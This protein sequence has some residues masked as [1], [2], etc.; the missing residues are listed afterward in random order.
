MENCKTDNIANK[1]FRSYWKW[2]K[3]SLSN[4]HLYQGLKY[5]K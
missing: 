3:L 2:D 1:L 5:L 4:K